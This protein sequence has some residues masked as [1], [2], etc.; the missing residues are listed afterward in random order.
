LKEKDMEL[1]KAKMSLAAE[2]MKKDKL[3]QILR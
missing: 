3:S 1:N 2:T